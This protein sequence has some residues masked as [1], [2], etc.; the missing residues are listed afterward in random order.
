MEINSLFSWNWIQCYYDIQYKQCENDKYCEVAKL[1]LL[2]IHVIEQAVRQE[3]AENENDGH[4]CNLYPFVQLT[5]DR[6]THW[7]E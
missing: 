6:V 5:F 4:V 2:G 3:Y 1:I 7:V